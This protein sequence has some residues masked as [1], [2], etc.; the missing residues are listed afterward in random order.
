[1]SWRLAVVAVGGLM[2]C[3]LSTTTVAGALTPSGGATAAPV[4]ARPLTHMTVVQ[5][6]HMT[7]P[8]DGLDDR[9][10]MV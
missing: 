3:G 7:H 1:M 6:T 2:V 10:V 4:A 5:A 9:A 8:S